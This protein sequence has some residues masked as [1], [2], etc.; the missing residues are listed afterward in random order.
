MK[1]GY[2]IGLVVAGVITISGIASGF[3]LLNHRNVAVSLEES[4]QAQYIANKSNYDNMVKSVKEMVQVTDMY[5]EDF[6]KIYTDLIE[7]RNQD[8]GL[9][10]KVVKESNPN[11]DPT[12]YTSLQREISANRKV[13]DKNQATISDKVREYNTYV[14]KKFIMAAITNR[15]TMNAEKFIVTSSSTVDAFNNGTADEINLRGE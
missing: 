11:L 8:T 3:T 4:I 7:G 9:L 2:L 15:E 5:A 13:F 10:F 6:E 1:K 14:K 12:V